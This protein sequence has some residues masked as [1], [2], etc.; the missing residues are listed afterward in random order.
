MIVIQRDCFDSFSQISVVIRQVPNSVVQDVSVGILPYRQ[1]IVGSFQN[2]VRYDASKQL[3]FSVARM[4]RCST[5]RLAFLGGRWSHI[6]SV[7]PTNAIVPILFANILDVSITFHV[8]CRIGLFGEILVGRTCGQSFFTRPGYS[9]LYSR[10]LI[11]FASDFLRSGPQN[12][13]LVFARQQCL[14]MKEF[15]ITIFLF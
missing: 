10:R 11:Q 1:G 14:S 7:N 13:N 4:P 2:G 6:R 5:T 12:R 9:N 15:D 8:S 3:M